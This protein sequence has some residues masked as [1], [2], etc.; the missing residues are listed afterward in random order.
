MELGY[1]VHVV[2]GYIYETPHFLLWRGIF[3]LVRG[4]GQKKGV[5]WEEEER[6]GEAGSKDLEKEKQED[7][8]T[9]DMRL[10]ACWH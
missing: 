5:K 9:G 3:Y 10:T 1:T 8:K 4:G 6:R 2:E 7:W